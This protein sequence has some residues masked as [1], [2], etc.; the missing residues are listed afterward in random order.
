MLPESG[1]ESGPLNPTNRPLSGPGL[2]YSLKP[3]SRNSHWTPPPPITLESVGGI[4]VGLYKA[5][6]W[7]NSR[8]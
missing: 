4:Q 3:V 5:P 2:D 8:I 1:P 6:N 7:V